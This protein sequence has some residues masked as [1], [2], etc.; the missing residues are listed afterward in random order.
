MKFEPLLENLTHTRSCPSLTPRH[1][2][3]CTCGLIWRIRLRTEMEMHNAWRKRA[4]EAE[5]S[6]IATRETI[7]W[8]AGQQNLFFAECSQAEEIILRCKKALG[9]EQHPN[10]GA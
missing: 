8:I 4:E 6:L 9:R 10:A 1:E 3:D 5:A 7:Q 2:E